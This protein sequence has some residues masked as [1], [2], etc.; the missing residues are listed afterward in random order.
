MT[1]TKLFSARDQHHAE[2]EAMFRAA[3][4]RRA[5]LLTTNLILAEVHR[6][7]L[8]LAGI[9]PDAHAFGRSEGS[10]VV[11]IEFATDTPP[12]ARSGA[13]REIEESA[14]QLHGRRELRG[15][16]GGRVPGGDELRSRLRG[17]G[18]RV[19]ETPWMDP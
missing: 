16:A 7:L 14:D 11:A 19:V 18:L 10:Q 2:A 9:Q 13:A 15:H 12:S 17:L 8:F 6:F 1:L 4:A 3:A 5:R